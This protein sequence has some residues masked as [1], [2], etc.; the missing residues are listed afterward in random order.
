MT[1]EFS[2]DHLASQRRRFL[3]HFAFMGLSSSLLP[4]VLWAKLHEQKAQKI[5][6]EMLRDAEEISGLHF[7]DTQREMMLEGVNQNRDIYEE[8]RQV[9]LDVSVPPAYRFSPI[10]PGMRFDTVRQPFRMSE[11]GALKKPRDLES[12]SFWPVTHLSALLQSHQL[13]SQELT[14]LYL[15]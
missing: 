2:S 8:I 6:R 13:S 11:I 4:G 3:Q 14:E 10:L 7:T 12:L 9:H 1:D 15:D 5:T